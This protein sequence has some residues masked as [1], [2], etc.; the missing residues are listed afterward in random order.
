V[1]VPC[2]SRAGNGRGH[3]LSRGKPLFASLR[4]KVDIFLVLEMDEARLHE[5]FVEFL[6]QGKAFERRQLRLKLGQ[7]GE[8]SGAEGATEALDARARILVHGTRLYNNT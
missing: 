5:A 6:R 4:W 2:R 3:L 8:P 7:G 1:N